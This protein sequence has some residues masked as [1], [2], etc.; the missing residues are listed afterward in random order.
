MIEPFGRGCHAP[1]RSKLSKVSEGGDLP[2]KK[3]QALRTET[4]SLRISH[5]QLLRRYRSAL[6]A[7]SDM[8]ATVGDAGTQV[9]RI[10][11]SRAGTGNSA[12]TLFGR[13]Q[14]TIEPTGRV[15]NRVFRN[16]TILGQCR[17]SHNRTCA[18]QIRWSV[19]AAPRRRA[20]EFR[21]LDS[22]GARAHRS[23]KAAAWAWRR[24]T[25]ADDGR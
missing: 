8:S 6:P 9:V 2:N 17:T 12:G 5:P 20:F 4:S 10:C 24:L 14:R 19:R 22:A 11:K 25:P 13:L 3:I 21:T 23:S 1:L 18:F 15:L 7:T 16:L